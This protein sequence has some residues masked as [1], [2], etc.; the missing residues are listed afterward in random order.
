MIFITLHIEIY[1]IWLL[2]LC[3]ISQ[4]GLA[5]ADIGRYLTKNLKG[6]MMPQEPTEITTHRFTR[7]THT[8]LTSTSC[9]SLIKNR[10]LKDNFYF[11]FF[12]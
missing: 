11:I 7:K 9:L 5:R 12:S 3:T 4:P 10:I 2:F 1:I 8:L 6:A